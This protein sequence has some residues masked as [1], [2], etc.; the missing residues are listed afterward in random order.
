MNNILS[1][2][3]ST[4]RKLQNSNVTGK[5]K[6]LLQN[7]S[8][9]VRKIMESLDDEVRKMRNMMAMMGESRTFSRSQDAFQAA[10]QAKRREQASWEEVLSA[11]KRLMM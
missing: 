6:E 1:E 3:S 8:K 7:M 2:F 4:L 5:D 11:I 10:I 9:C